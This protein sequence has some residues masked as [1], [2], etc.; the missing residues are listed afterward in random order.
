MIP[1]KIVKYGYLNGYEGCYWN[2]N[3]QVFLCVVQNRTVDENT[4]NTH[5]GEGNKA[6]WKSYLHG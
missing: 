4:G 1:E 5:K 3:I 6:F 2:G